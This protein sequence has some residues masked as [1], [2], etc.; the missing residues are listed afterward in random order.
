[1]NPSQRFF[2]G[3]GGSRGQSCGP[4]EDDTTVYL[5]FLVNLFADSDSQRREYKML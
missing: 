1:M 4:N 3:R 5:D 2:G